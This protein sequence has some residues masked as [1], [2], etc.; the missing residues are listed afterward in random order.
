LLRHAGTA[1]GA[2]VTDYEDDIRSVGNEPY[3]EG[4]VEFVFFV[5]DLRCGC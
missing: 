1:F 2:F 3:A 4:G 5:E